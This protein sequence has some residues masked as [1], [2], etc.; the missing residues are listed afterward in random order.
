[1]TDDGWNEYWGW[2]PQDSGDGGG[3]AGGGWSQ[4]WGWGPQDSGDGGGG[5]DGGW[6]ELRGYGRPDSGHDGGG[7]GFSEFGGGQD[8]GAERTWVGFQR[9]IISV[10]LASVLLVGNELSAPAPGSLTAVAGNEVTVEETD[11][12]DGGGLSLSEMEQVLYDRDTAYVRRRVANLEYCTAWTWSIEGSPTNSEP[13]IDDLDEEP[14]DNDDPFVLEINGKTMAFSSNTLLVD[15]LVV[16][17]NAYHE[18]LAI[19]DTDG[20]FAVLC[21]MTPSRFH[22]V[23]GEPRPQTHFVELDEYPALAAEVINSV[24]D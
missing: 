22:Q 24:F 12:Q 14:A 18:I 15:A 10:S 23:P 21:G 7:G 5:A 11:D 1:M 19:E 2:G 13:G 17:V 9:R 20:V 8:S 16:T 4:Y 6:N 3:G